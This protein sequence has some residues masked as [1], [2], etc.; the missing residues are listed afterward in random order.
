VASHNGEQIKRLLDSG[1]DGVIVPMVSTQAEVDRIIEWCKYPPL[2][3][4]SYGIARAQGYGFDF[5]RYTA[6][7]NANSIIIIQIESVKGVDAAEDLLAHQ[8]IDG[9]MV[10]P[11][12]LSGSLGIPGQL[13]DRR[14]T[15]SCA[16][17]IEACRRHGKACG[18]HLVEPTEAQVLAAFDEGYTFVVLGSDV[19]VLWK[20]S[21]RMRAL[22]STHRGARADVSR[23]H[24]T[25]R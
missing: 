6:T 7:W 11:Y 20:W 12:D 22:V 16:R 24:V 2:G 25:S 13:S 17:V 5:E 19:F 3:E 23:G 1:A 8:A 15:E 21:E 14:V 10:G 18:T 9:A 4:R